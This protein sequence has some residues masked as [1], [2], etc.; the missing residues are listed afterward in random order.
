MKQLPLILSVVALIIATAFGV[1][2]LTNNLSSSKADTSTEATDS[3]GTATSGD[4]VYFDLDVVIQDYDMANDL[5]SVVETKAQ[6]IQAEIE[7][8]GKKLE[9]DVVSFQ[10]KVNKGL[11][12]RSVAEVQGQKL[13]QQEVEFNQYVQ[14]QNQ[15]VMEEQQVM[16]NQLADAIKTYVEK[17]NNEKQYSMILTNQGGSPVI[18]GSQTLNITADILSGLNDEYIET[19]KNK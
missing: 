4:I 14:K 15:I 10:E 19:K 16:M 5:R 3:L 2:S 6:N 9:S 12:T 11:M 8:R 7:R 1:L 17:Y 13:Q 18:A